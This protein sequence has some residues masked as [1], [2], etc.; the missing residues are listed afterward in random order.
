MAERFWVHVIS[1][2]A[3]GMVTGISCATLNCFDLA[4]GDMLAFSI[5]RILGVKHGE[6]WN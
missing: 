1:V 5:T 3:T 2:T 4:D 6:H